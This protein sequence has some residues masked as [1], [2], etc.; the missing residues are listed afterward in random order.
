MISTNRIAYFKCSDV[1]TFS[2]HLGHVMYSDQR[3]K[4]SEITSTIRGYG[5]VHT[6]G[7]EFKA[8]KRRKKFDLISFDMVNE[9]KVVKFECSTELLLLFI[10]HLEIRFN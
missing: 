2:C 8:R 5:V 6:G 9:I 4:T 7:A 3:V 1:I 10:S